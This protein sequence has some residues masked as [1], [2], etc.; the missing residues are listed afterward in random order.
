MIS[1]ASDIEPA[2]LK[3]EHFL[4]LADCLLDFPADLFALAFSFQIGI[5]GHSSDFLFNFTFHARETC[6]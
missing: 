6:L 2:S 3:P 1:R 4:D 5:V